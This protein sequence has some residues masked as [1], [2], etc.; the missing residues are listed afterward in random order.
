MLECGI[1]IMAYPPPQQ[2][3]ESVQIFPSDPVTR[4][5][6]PCMCLQSKEDKA[7]EFKLL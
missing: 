5:Q 2:K 6:K 1:K 4:T 3:I 7:T